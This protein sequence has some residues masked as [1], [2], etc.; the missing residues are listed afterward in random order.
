[1]TQVLQS[2][3]LLVKVLDPKILLVFHWTPTI[4][5]ILLYSINKA[6]VVV[7]FD[8]GSFKIYRPHLGITM[9]ICKEDLN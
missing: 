7:T 1:M 2:C 9:L 3:Q 5:I 6:D 4:F 8:C